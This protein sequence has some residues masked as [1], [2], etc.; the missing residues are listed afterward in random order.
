MKEGFIVIDDNIQNHLRNSLWTSWLGAD[1]ENFISLWWK[2]LTRHIQWSDIQGCWTSA[3]SSHFYSNVPG[4]DMTGN[5]LIII[6]III[7]MFWVFFMTTLGKRKK[8]KESLS[9]RRQYCQ[10]CQLCLF[11]LEGHTTSVHVRVRASLHASLCILAAANHWL[12]SQPAPVWNLQVIPLG[13]LVY[14]AVFQARSFMRKIKDLCCE[15]NFLCCSF[16]YD[17]SSMDFH[18]SFLFREHI[19]QVSTS[20]YLMK[21]VGS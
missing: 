16:S 11:P 5:L 12:S 15:L 4:F 3:S 2:K 19:H 13:S 21:L 1:L 17:L 8:K 9:Q 10:L 20:H 18:Y 14:L 7:Y 6:Y